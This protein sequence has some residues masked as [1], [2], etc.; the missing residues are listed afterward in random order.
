MGAKTEKKAAEK[1]SAG[2]AAPALSPSAAFEKHGYEFFGPP[3]TFILI[4]V[5]PILI[6]IFPFVCND[7]SGCPA[8]SLLS[9]ST[10][11][12]GTLKREVGWPEDGLK[13]LYDTQTTLYVLGYYLLLLVLQIVLPGR[14]VDG[15]VLAS[16]GRHKYKFNTLL[17]TILILGGCGAGSYVYGAD[18][19]VWTFIWDNYI[20][21][22]TANII[23]S[24]AFSLFVYLRS[25]TVPAP[26]QPN[27]THRELAPGGCSGNPIYDFF[28]G[29]ELNPR[30]TLPI[31]FVSEASRIFDI[32]VFCEMR[33][34]LLGWII[35][36]LANI[37][38]QYK[39]NSGEITISILLVTF[40]QAFYVIDSFFMEPAILTTMDVIMDGFGFMLSFGD[41]VWVPFIFSIQTRYLAVYPLHV[42]PQG[43]AMVLG[44]QAV[45]YYVF[46]STN[47]Q[48]NRFRTNPND[49]RVKHLKYIET[50]AGS[51]LLI[52]GWW[53]CAR[54]INYLGDWVMSWAY[55]LPTGVAGYLMLDHVD[56]VTGAVEKRAVQTP[57]VRGWG[58]PV[59]YFFMVYFTILLLHRER[60][61]EAKCRRKYG[62]DWDRYTSIVK[63]RI[64]PG[65]Y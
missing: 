18:F 57:E 1:K 29:R 14:E 3:G 39:V 21:I 64:V 62:K 56:P 6:Y 16:G 8:P 2:K 48:K 53:G 41:L 7:I 32:K 65:I 61:D 19:P 31:P 13:G 28:M 30:I 38:H 24:V 46:R 40:F 11:V 42:G 52:S 25:F 51:R 26:G 17:S 36:N 44:V 10:L 63:S 55:C 43:I 35:L 54:H 50:A 60:R 23:I 20:Q 59:T 22:I 15:V 27:P 33:P 58:I 4:T 5:L 12:L 34:G 9:P 49:P 45:G 37:A 47:N